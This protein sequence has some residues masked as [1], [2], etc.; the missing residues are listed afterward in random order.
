M[1]KLEKGIIRLIS[2]FVFLSSLIESIALDNDLFIKSLYL[3][4]LNI[5]LLLS[6]F[7]L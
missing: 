5:L 1:W 7:K 4:D 2:L 6:L 3:F